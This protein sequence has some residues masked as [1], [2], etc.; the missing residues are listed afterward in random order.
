MII[1]Q[2]GGIIAW[3]LAGQTNGMLEALSGL[4]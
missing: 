4:V 3:K 1:T 2:F